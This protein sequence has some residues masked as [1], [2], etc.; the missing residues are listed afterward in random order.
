MGEYAEPLADGIQ[1]IRY[2]KGQA[3]V[4]HHDYYP[5]RH[6]A[7]GH[8]WDPTKGG[9]NRFATIFLYLSDV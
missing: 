8:A 4:A 1:I 6:A 5:L 7:K 3:Y 2:E 9:S